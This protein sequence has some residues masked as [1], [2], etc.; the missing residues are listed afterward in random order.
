MLALDRIY[1][2]GLHLIAI[3]AHDSRAARRASDHLPVVARV[4]LEGG[5][6]LPRVIP[7]RAWL[8]RAPPAI[9]DGVHRARSRSWFAIGVAMLLGAAGSAPDAATPQPEAERPAA[10]RFLVATEQVRG[11]FFQHSV[12]L[13]L[14]LCRG[15]R[16]R[17]GRQP[18]H[19]PR[20]ARLRARERPTVR[21]RS[22]S[23]GRSS[24]GRCSCCCAPDPR[25]SARFA[26]PATC[27]SPSI[28]RSCS[29]APGIPTPPRICACTRVMRAGVRVSST[30]RSRAA[31]GS[32]R[33]RGS[34]RSSTTRPT[35]LWKKL[36][37]R[38]HRLLTRGG[39]ARRWAAS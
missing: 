3:E 35:E 25:P 4:K 34:K 31:T 28:P 20:P 17:P 15:R 36:H 21:A 27:S 38:H 19:R 16:D 12:V 39:G 13:L 29:I 23:A 14:E 2:R 8:A 32:S 30:P 24:A 11:S 5:S 7:S 9:P 10:G 26:S 18:P 6:A 33:A 37:L 1:A 22:I